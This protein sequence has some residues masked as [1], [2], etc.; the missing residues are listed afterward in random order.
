MNPHRDRAGPASPQAASV[1]Q[2][3]GGQRLQ[4][5]SPCL[6]A[7]SLFLRDPDSDFQT[8][9][10]GGGQELG[11]C[12]CGTGPTE[13]RKAGGAFPEHADL[14][15]SPSS[16]GLRWALWAL[17]A[18]PPPALWST[19]SRGGHQCPHPQDTCGVGLVFLGVTF[20]WAAGHSAQSRV[21]G[22]F[23]GPFRDAPHPCA[24]HLEGFLT[25]GGGGNRAS[26]VLSLQAVSRDG[27]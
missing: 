1:L 24:G 16:S 27:E 12:P 23:R 17:F 22:P 20:S 3:L 9:R 6:G 26:W 4:G 5:G 21:G 14:N 7:P 18:P 11:G 15:P 19:E 10:P 8:S 13:C 2:G 25:P